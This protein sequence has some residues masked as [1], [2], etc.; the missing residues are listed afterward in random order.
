MMFEQRIYT[1]MKRKSI[2]CILSQC[3]MHMFVQSV[4]YVFA[5]LHGIYYDMSCMLLVL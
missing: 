2:D 5:G 3:V 4:F 1:G